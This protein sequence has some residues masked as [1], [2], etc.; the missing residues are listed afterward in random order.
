M[1]R[2][3]QL[4]KVGPA[5]ELAMRPVAP[6]FNLITGDNGLGKSFLLDLA[7]WALTRTWHETEAVPS[8]TP[9]AIGYEFDGETRLVR[10]VAEWVPTA[11]A[12]KR[13]QGRPPNPGL[14]LYAR[15]DGSFSV[16][17]PARNYRLYKRA[18]GSEVE[19]P[20]AY[21]FTPAQVLHGL[22]RTIQDG[23]R[24]REQVICSGLIYDWTLWQRSHDPSFQ[25]LTALLARLGPEGDALKPGQPAYPLPDD[26]RGIPTVHM[27]YGLD[28]PITYAPAGVQRM[29]KL[30]Y[31]LAWALAAHERESNAM[32]IAMSHQVIVLIDEPETHLHPRW[33][34]TVLPS[35][36]EAI[37]GWHAEAAPEVQIL[38]ATHSPLVLASMEPHF[39]ADKDA[40]WVLDLVNGVVQLKQDVWKKRGDVSRWLRSDVFDLEQAT[41]REA[42]T[43]MREAAKLMVSPDPAP[44]SVLALDHAL[45]A[46]LSEQDPFFLR[47]RHYMERLLPEGDP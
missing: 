40:L 28:V 30:A 1:L 41:S 36:H 14:V 42:E 26:D 16:W 46:V 9:A 15:V 8:G 38:V 10:Q 22:R 37:R 29:S 43:V 45:L 32:G 47:W 21:Q 7:W 27:P 25:L 44:E 12:W 17:D 24:E 33:Q 6:R 20:P 11:R 13:K 35:L 31:L 5:A 18:D 3:L 23:G 4:F 34:R 39:D 2:S 19:A